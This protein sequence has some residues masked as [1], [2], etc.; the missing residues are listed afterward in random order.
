MSKKTST[1]AAQS[2]QK[3]WMFV[4]H[5]QP[6]DELLCCGSDFNLKL[7]GKL[8]LQNGILLCQHARLERVRMALATLC[9]SMLICY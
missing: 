1:L 9:D 8:E 2:H 7:E 6:T 3:W 5:F 4:L